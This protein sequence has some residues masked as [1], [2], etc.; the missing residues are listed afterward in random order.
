CLFR[1]NAGDS[2]WLYQLP[3][4]LAYTNVFTTGRYFLSNTSVPGINSATI[5][6]FP[7]FLTLPGRFY[8]VNSNKINICSVGNL[9]SSTSTAGFTFP[10]GVVI[11]SMKAFKSGYTTSPATESKVLVVATD[12]TA[13]GQGHKVY[14]LNLAANGDINSTPARVYTGFGKIVDI[15]FKKGL[16][17]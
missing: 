11:K 12:E 10:T 17:L 2:T 16:G 1:N 7:T 9:A 13:I 8:Y 3:V 5:F 15:A 4:A 6:S 14:F